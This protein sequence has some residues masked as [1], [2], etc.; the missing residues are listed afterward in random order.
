MKVL[1]I[2]PARKSCQRQ[3]PLGIAS[4]A[5]LLKSK[6]YE[7]NILDAEI[8]N[9]S[10]NE[11]TDYIKIVAPDVVGISFFTS[12][13]FSAFQIAKF[14][15]EF[16]SIV[17]GGGHHVS[18]LPKEVLSDVSDFDYLVIGEGEISSLELLDSLNTHKPR[19]SEIKGIGFREDGVV[20]ITPPRELINNLDDLPDPAWSLLPIKKYA[21]YSIMGSR[22]CP[23]NCIF[24][25]S[26]QFWQRKIRTFSPPR[27]VNF[28][29][30]L[31]NT[32]GKNYFD[33]MDD[34]FTI[35]KDW[36]REICEELL[37]RKIDIKWECQGRVESYD[38]NLFKLMKK[39]G[40]NKISF[41]IESGSQRILDV[42]KKNIDKDMALKAI[43]TAR[44]AG[45]ERIG[46]FFM[47]GFPS[48]TA[49]EMEETYNFSRL[50]NADMVSFNPAIIHPGTELYK[51]AL[52][53]GALKNDFNW[54]K[55]GFYSSGFLTP[56]DMP[57]YE[58]K[59]FNRQS[60]EN[61]AKR[62]YVRSFL[63][64]LYSFTGLKQHYFFET[65]IGLS[66]GKNDLYLFFDEFRLFVK[67]HNN[68]IKVLGVFILALII[69][70][71]K[72][73]RRFN[74]KFPRERWI[75]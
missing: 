58:S 28:I 74:K 25:G 3:M 60:L 2:N 6:G 21:S 64:R 32:Y 54:H 49:S 37:R 72:F 67:Q 30:E 13:R 34:T 50:L 36:A 23:N 63:E 65:Q 56:E 62:F 45:I 39:A 26:P 59:E 55:T 24:C 11:I 68:L 9:Y 10:L 7:V 51:I 48:E 61:T 73:L 1:L 40:C 75:F 38:I 22:G 18:A 43:G 31:V 19:L 35:K 14:S 20:K 69:I 47:L 53:S 71:L 12:D 57:T 70:S 4:I 52:S 33:F 5:A 29:E 17:I 15:K 44:K 16:G 42:M 46:T 27:F 8:L 66:A 41:G